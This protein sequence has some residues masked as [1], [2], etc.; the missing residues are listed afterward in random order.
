MKS[1]LSFILLFTCLGFGSVQSQ[2]QNIFNYGLTGGNTISLDEPTV[3]QGF[4]LEVCGSYSLD[5]TNVWDFVNLDVPGF[6]F[7]LLNIDEVNKTFCVSIS[8]DNYATA[9]CR[10]IIVSME[11]EDAAGNELEVSSQPLEICLEQITCACLY[12]ELT[13]IVCYNNGTADFEDD[14]WSFDLIVFNNISNNS[15]WSASPLDIS[16]Y[17][18][19]KQTIF[20]GL[21]IDVDSIKLN[22][23]DDSFPDDCNAKL[24]V[25]APESCSNGCGFF[26]TSLVGECQDGGTEDNLS[27]DVYNVQIDISSNSIN[28]WEVYR[29]YVNDN[30]SELIATGVGDEKIDL[31]DQAIIYGDWVLSGYLVNDPECSAVDFID[32]PEFCSGCQEVII[33]NIVCNDQNTENQDDDTWSFDIQV[34][35]GT[36]EEFRITEYG[37][38]TVYGSVV[39]IEA[40]VISNCIEVI[41]QDVDNPMECNSYVLVCPPETC[42]ESTNCPLDVE[43]GKIE[44]VKIGNEAGFEIGVQVQGTFGACWKI[45]KVALNGATEVLLEG[46]GDKIFKLGPFPENIDFSLVA[47]L[48]DNSNCAFDF[49]ID[50][51][52]CPG[53]QENDLDVRN[54]TKTKVFPNPV[55]DNMLQIQFSENVKSFRIYDIQGKLLI[56]QEVVNTLMSQSFQVESGVYF[57]MSIDK[58]GNTEQ[59]KFVKL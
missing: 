33:N 23:F 26:L 12:Y 14:Y 32:A 46:E 3:C 4:P 7:V 56:E 39:N 13:N 28:T 9:E 48:C 59:Q 10:D 22:I 31:G 53:L 37:I 49:E 35:G 18:G 27:D 17:Y 15:T 6:N 8:E 34:L 55:E 51:P 52:E 11:F 16:G 47:E 24:E 30:F 54:T 45:T 29:T 36:G 19:V 42:S 5:Q 50:A 41:V 43:V 38:Q 58:D 44:C 57:L 2:V 25:E 21:I 20:P 40:G 1:I